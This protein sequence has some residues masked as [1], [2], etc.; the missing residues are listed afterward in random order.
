MDTLDVQ[1]EVVK[2]VV[3]MRLKGYLSGDGGKCLHETAREHFKQNRIKYVL[4]FSECLFVNSP[5][6]A[7]LME[8][9]FRVVD[10]LNGEILLSGLN[11]LQRRVFDIAGIFPS[12]GEV[13]TVEEGMQQLS[14]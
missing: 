13:K 4:D 14:Q 11:D 7:A 9:V 10:D 6:V 12:A 3:V 8:L 2:N 1:V 5:G